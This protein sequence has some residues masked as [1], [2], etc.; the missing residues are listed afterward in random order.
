MDSCISVVII[1][2][3]EEKIIERCIQ[4][5]IYALKNIEKYEI[6]L[7]DSFSTDRTIEIAKKYPIKII[8]LQ[9][10]WHHS[11]SA[12]EYIGYLHSK[13][14]YI[15]FVGADMLLR[16]NWF[17]NS[18]KY[19]ENNIDVAGVSGIIDNSFI[20]DSCSWIVQQRIQKNF[21]SMQTGDVDVLGGPAIFKKEILDHIGCYHPFLRAGEE[22]ELSYRIK[23][24]GY[25]LIR[26]PY[27]MVTHKMECF[28]LIDYLKKYQ[29]TYTREIGKA[30]RYSYDTNINIF[31]KYLPKLFSATLFNLLFIILFSG[32]LSLILAK[33]VILFIIISICYVI[34]FVISY[35]KRRSI[36][37]ALLSLLII[38]IRGVA[39]TVGFLEGLPSMSNYPT[40][41]II[42]E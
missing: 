13:Y 25:R 6:I 28:S 10:H 38:H 3:N 37:D 30:I 8:Q 21:N 26:L 7:V 41:C 9:K 15:C 2:K 1:S 35:N 39:I 14:D 27:T 34:L 29:W 32:V 5:T 23:N 4:S 19:L 20:S 16:A 33:S 24:N 18:I 40:S 42:I 12:G 31:Y 11:P 17:Y 36:Y 22:T